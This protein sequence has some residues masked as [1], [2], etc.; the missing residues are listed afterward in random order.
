M[1]RI[2]YFIITGCCLLSC[3]RP[4]VP[5]ENVVEMTGAPDIYPDYTGLVIPPNI[6]PLNF[7]IEVPGEEYISRVVSP[8]GKEM[9]G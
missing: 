8:S 2:I 9:V 1:K 7:E 3:G 4:Q 5:T 6:A